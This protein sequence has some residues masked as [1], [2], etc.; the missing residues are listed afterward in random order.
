MI[1]FPDNSRRVM[2]IFPDNSHRVP[3]RT[4]FIIEKIR[5][6]DNAIEKLVTYAVHELRVILSIS[7][8]SIKEKGV[9]HF[10]TTESTVKGIP[11]FSDSCV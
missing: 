9:H 10:F 4:S 2:I 3:I 1:V 7:S 5:S 11:A 6:V 8:E